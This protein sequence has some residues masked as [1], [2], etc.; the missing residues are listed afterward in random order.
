MT[1]GIKC[2]QSIFNPATCWP[3]LHPKTGTLH[4]PFMIL[5]S[6]VPFCTL[7]LIKKN[8]FNVDDMTF[9]LI[10]KNKIILCTDNC[11]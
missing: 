7:F 5:I 11:D 3:C 8:Q 6:S 4:L 2:G 10:Y 1:D 9:S